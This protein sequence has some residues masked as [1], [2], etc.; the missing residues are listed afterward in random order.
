MSVVD[1]AKALSNHASKRTVDMDDLKYAIQR[2]QDDMERPE[3]EVIQSIK[4]NY[5][6]AHC[7]L[8]FAKMRHQ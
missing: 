8:L 6:L 7:Y 4:C 2:R 5:C 3:K 1:E